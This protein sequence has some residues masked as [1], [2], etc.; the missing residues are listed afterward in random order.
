MQTWKPT[1]FNAD[2]GRSIP[3]EN[4]AEREQICQYILRNP[5]SEA[6]V[7]L[8]HPKDTVIYRSRL[9]PKINRNFQI[10]DPV[11]FLAVLSQHIPDK[12]VQ[13]IRY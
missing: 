11:D 4:R 10:F 9:N 1:G 8:E 7:T 2:W 5:F 6:K 3:P 13:M 12:G